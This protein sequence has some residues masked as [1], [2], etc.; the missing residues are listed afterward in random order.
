VLLSSGRAQDGAGVR[1][2][3]GA[4]ASPGRRAGLGV[5]GSSM[6]ICERWHVDYAHMHIE[7]GMQ[8]IALPVALH[9]KPAQAKQDVRTTACA[10]GGSTMS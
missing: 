1:V 6:D 7:V 2:A 3:D 10:G 8:Q 9:R 5:R 4:S